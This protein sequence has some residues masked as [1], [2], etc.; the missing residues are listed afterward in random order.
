[1]DNAVDAG[2]VYCIRCNNIVIRN[3][4]L[5]NNYTGIFF[6][7]T[8]NSRIE[9]V[10]ISNN[11]KS[12][13]WLLSSNNNFLKD[14]SISGNYFG[15][16]L[17]SSNNNFIVKNVTQKNYEGLSLYASSENAI[18]DNDSSQNSTLGIALYNSNN[19]LIQGNNVSNNLFGGIFLERSSNNIL[20]NNTSTLSL[21]A[22]IHLALNSN[23]NEITENN[24]LNNNYGIYLYWSDSN[25]V[26]HNNFINNTKTPQAAVYGIGNRFDDD[27]PSGGNYW[28]DYNGVDLKSG[29]QQ[30]Q[31]GSDGIGDTPYCFKGGCDRYPFMK[32]NGW[33]EPKEPIPKEFW[34]EVK[35]DEECI[36]QEESLT[37]K[38]KC[39]PQGWIL[40][41]PN[42]E[43]K[44]WQEIPAV[45][46]IED[47]TDETLGWTKKVFLN[48]DP[49]K[50]EE[51]KKKTEKLISLYYNL[52]KG[53]EFT[54]ELNFGDENEDVVYLQ[55]ILKEEIGVPIY[56]EDI[57]ATG[58]F[59]KITENALKAFQQKYGLVETGKVDETTR[60]KLNSLLK[61]LLLS[62]KYSLIS[63]TSAICQQTEEIINFLSEEF[64]NGVNL[65]QKVG[66]ILSIIAQE[67]GPYRNYDNEL[68]SFDCG[69]GLMQITDNK[70]LGRGSKI[71][72][73]F[74]NEKC[75]PYY[76]TQGWQDKSRKCCDVQNC[77][78]ITPDSL[79]Y[80]SKTCKC[81]HYTNTLQGV[82]ANIKDGLE[83]VKEKYNL[84]S[85]QTHYNKCINEYATNL[86]QWQEKYGKCN[87]NN[88]DEMRVISSI[89][90]YNQGTP[91]RSQDA[92][93][94]WDCYRKEENW[95]KCREEVNHYITNPRH[96]WSTGE[97]DL[98]RCSGNLSY[99]AARPI[100]D[101]ETVIENSCGDVN[102]FRNCLE[103]LGSGEP[104]YLEKIGNHLKS[105]DR[106]Y[107]GSQCGSYRNVNLGDKLICV[108]SHKLVASLFSP[109]IIQVKD[110][111]GQISGLVN[112][113]I[114]E[115]IPF[116]TYDD[117]NNTVTI[118]F[119]TGTYTFTITGTRK[120]EYGLMVYFTDGEQTG[121]F[122]AADIPIST[123]TIH[124]YEID[125]EKV[126]K[127][128]KGITLQ[129][130]EDGDGIFEKTLTSDIILTY[131]EFIIQTN[132]SIDFQPD[133]FNLKTKGE[134]VTVYIE[135]PKNFDVNKIDVSTIL[136]NDLIPA[137]F[138]PTKIGDYDSDGI[139]DLMVKFERS[140]AKTILNTG[141]RVPIIITGNVSYK[142]QYLK[143]K[144]DDII[145]IIGE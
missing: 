144:G 55:I 106:N 38:L 98:W 117:I 123:S 67:I 58:Y 136:L 110:S 129:I 91:E 64:L 18:E 9:N 27:Y 112:S 116:S 131:E 42:P 62:E 89:Y 1:M 65:Q 140:K 130:D 30:D 16:R 5:S 39:L 32:E 71:E 103:T 11:E 66:L 50:Q 48:Y 23:N 25:K 114:K 31:E 19:N 86:E 15:I 87:I 51:W 96:C 85:V 17:D 104:F 49:E 105:L 20:K 53:F 128:E 29:P 4:S 12:G 143:F 36:Y 111:Q 97:E 132:T 90:R 57:P 73:Y 100:K 7:K 134:F 88:C 56:P 41:V 138:K 68:V 121:I 8:E 33:K 118:F 108:N 43:K 6:Y 2:T 28:S 81:R 72:C 70:A 142:G 125:L 26:Y 60:K 83:I 84:P 109:G 75:L 124:Q 14:N 107:K 59:G 77:E 139:P 46:Q 76:G 34:V 122:T 126:L 80:R 24:S 113:E 145:T 47:V 10:N 82:K 119:P 35:E 94:I 101:F 92:Y 21:S 133:T 115:E 40:K 45:T 127:D 79:C 95:D 61:E 44:S 37:T 63:R 137:L 52:L 135:L 93:K 141:E 120:G 54:K 78:S 102:N 22:G 69:R 74:D 13:I 3:L 99:L